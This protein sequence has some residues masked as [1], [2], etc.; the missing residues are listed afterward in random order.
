MVEEFFRKQCLF[1]SFPTELCSPVLSLVS[2]NFK[3]QTLSCKT[4]RKEG[5]DR[6]RR[7]ERKEIEIDMNHH[8]QDKVN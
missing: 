3:S 4:G 1:A 6:E 5:R 8:L 2:C 7:R